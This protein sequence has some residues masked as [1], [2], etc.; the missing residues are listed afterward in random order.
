MCLPCAKVVIDQGN[1]IEAEIDRRLATLKQVRGCALA[2]V[3]MAPS[4]TVDE[5]MEDIVLRAG[6]RFLSALKEAAESYAVVLTGMEKEARKKWPN[7]DGEKYERKLG[8]S[9]SSK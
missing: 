3:M 7:N 8:K 5:E 6:E 1:R 4:V 2:S 9:G